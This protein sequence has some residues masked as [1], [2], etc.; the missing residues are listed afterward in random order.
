MVGEARLLR[1]VAR[2]RGMRDGINHVRDR[3]VDELEVI[4]LF[5]RKLY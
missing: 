1:G 5:P 3:I 2:V 4:Y